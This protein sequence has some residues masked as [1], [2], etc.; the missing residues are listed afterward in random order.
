MP[1]QWWGWYLSVGVDVSWALEHPSCSEPD[2][3]VT[4]AEDCSAKELS[5][6]EDLLLKVS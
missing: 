4:A 3:H 2:S 1:L 6:F 5:V